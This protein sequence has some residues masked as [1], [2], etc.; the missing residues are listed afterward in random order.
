MTIE[1]FKPLEIANYIYPYPPYYP[2][3]LE[4]SIYDF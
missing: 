3:F 4:L 2:I 1:I